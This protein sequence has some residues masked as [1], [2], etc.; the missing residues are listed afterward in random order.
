[1]PSPQRRLFFSFF[2]VTVLLAAASALCLTA[3]GARAAAMAAA[4]ASGGYAGKMLSKVVE[5]W[6]PPPALKGDF[7]VQVKVALDGAGHVQNCAPAR[8]SGMEALDSSA[9]GAVRQI[10]SFGKPPHGKPLEV[11][12]S[13]WT[14]MP[15]GKVRAAPIDDV[16]ALRQEERARTKAEAAMSDSRA[17]SAEE[18]ARERA[19]A[20]AKAAGVDLPTVRSAPVAPA[21][22]Q[23]APADPAGDKAS[24]HSRGKDGRPPKVVGYSQDSSPATVAV[25][26]SGSAASGNSGSGP[27][28]AA[29]KAPALTIAPTPLPAPP[30][31]KVEGTAANAAQ[32]AV[33]EATATPPPASTAVQSATQPDRPLTYGPDSKAQFR[34]GKKHN[35]YFSNLGRELAN[36]IIIPVETPLGTYYPTVRLTVDPSTGAIQDFAFL[37]KSGDKYLDSFVRRGIKKAGSIPPPPADIGTTLDITLTLVRR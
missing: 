21:S 20:A 7:Q 25:G 17:A 14:G 37:E 26:V 1:M 13:F 30:P 18:R 10:G 15:R 2:P 12:L 16:E 8:P 35:K 5:I 19:E 6:A 32:G 9:C 27:A 28:A 31:S 11:H 24:G 29:K 34:Y 3:P 22:R 33:T 4:D 23:P 36:A